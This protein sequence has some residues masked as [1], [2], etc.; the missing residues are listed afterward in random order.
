[1]LCVSS[2]TGPVGAGGCFLIIVRWGD[3]LHPRSL[4][5]DTEGHPIIALGEAQLPRASMG[6]SPAVRGRTSLPTPCLD[7]TAGVTPLL[8]GCGE[9]PTVPWASSGTNPPGR[10]KVPGTTGRGGGPGS[11]Y[12]LHCH[13]PGG[14][15]SWS[16]SWQPGVG[17]VGS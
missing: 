15:R 11:P 12:G 7:T 1:M 3:V 6:V 10:G 4:S 16:I 5:L 2:D 13:Q 17:S 9:S 14:L 8:L